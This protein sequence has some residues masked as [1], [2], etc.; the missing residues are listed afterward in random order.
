MG[1]G[2]G[3][4][5]HWKKSEVLCKDDTAERPKQ[6]CRDAAGLVNLSSIMPFPRPGWFCTKLPVG[7]HTDHR[8]TEW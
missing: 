1:T 3:L 5:G 8:I 7:F 6:D 2:F 4:P